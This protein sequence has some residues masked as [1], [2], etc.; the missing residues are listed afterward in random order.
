MCLILF[1]WDAHPTYKLI[2]AANRDEFYDRPS[3]P[4]GFWE[5]HPGILA[6]RDLKG[7][8]TWLG[9]HKKGR[10]TAITNYRDMSDINP[11]AVSRGK[12][13]LDYLKSGTTP[14]AYLKDVSADRRMY[15]GFNL[16]VGDQNALY[17]YSNAENKV[18]A[19]PPGVHGLSNHLLNTNWPK[20]ETGRDALTQIVQDKNPQPEA[21]FSLLYNKDIAPD[22]DLPN[23]GVALEWE[24]ALSARFIEIE[25][26]GTYSSTVLLLDR[27]GNVS[28][29]ERVYDPAEQQFRE[30]E[31]HF[32]IEK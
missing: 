20:V 9:V 31:F 21:L 29:T 26:Y 18:R 7:G 25:N 12:L 19:V 8:G 32:A 28:F 30:Q 17:Y 24:R 2:L 27:L 15:N 22:E 6:G 16:L 13:T 5:S 10:F 3:A 11:D 1:A 4:A 23:T 14:E